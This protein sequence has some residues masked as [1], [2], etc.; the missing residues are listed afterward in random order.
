MYLSHLKIENFR[1]FGQGDSAF[2]MALQ[3]GVT[4]IVGENDAG[5]SAVIDAI[6]L[7]LG[8]NDH[9]WARVEDTDFHRLDLQRE[10]QICCD[11]AGLDE[12]D[13]RT[14]LE[15]LTYPKDAPDAP[16]LQL[17]W[18]CKAVG[19]SAARRASRRCT[20]RCGPD[21]DGPELDMGARDLLRVTYLRPL[22]DAEKALSP[23]RYSRLAQVLHSTTKL[24]D[25]QNEHDSEKP[26][27]EQELSV[28]GIARLINELMR[29]QKGVKSIAEEITGLLQSLSL[30]GDQLQGRIGVGETP[31]EEIQVQRLLE[32]LELRLDGDG[33]A[34]LGSSNV[35]FMACELLLLASESEGHKLLLIEE[36]EAHLHA[37]RQLRAMQFLLDQA[38]TK[39][40]QVLVTT[41]SSHLASSIPVENLQIMNGGRSFSLAPGQTRLDP[42]DYAFLDRFIDATKANLF[43]AKA[44]I[45]VEGH[46]EQLILPVIARMLGRDLT[47]HGVSIVN[48]GGVG[49]RRY[50]RVFMRAEGCGDLKI[51]VACVADR[52]ILPN[53]APKLLGRLDEDGNPKPKRQ[54]KWESDFQTDEA[55]GAYVETL[56]ARSSGQYVST[57]VSDRWTLEYDLALGPMKSDGHYSA[58]AAED[59]YV[60]AMW[61]KELE[62]I[63][64]GK[65]TCQDVIE[66]ARSNFAALRKSVVVQEGCTEEEVLAANVYAEIVAGNISK[67]TVAQCLGR[68]WED[69][70]RKEQW[71]PEDVRSMLPTYLVKAIEHVTPEYDGGGDEKTVDE[72]MGI[73]SSP[74]SVA[75]T[76]S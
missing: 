41:H 43:F 29:S 10:M 21:G 51:P 2:E 16:V 75:D 65:M 58:A 33:I 46:A 55:L 60:A 56:K 67:P 44:V 54:W 36:P 27:G 30:R 74:G 15:Y 76:G 49:L 38:E 71:S 12:D 53:C 59:L 69:K 14:F 4:A 63:L 45:I 6:R 47:E 18:I 20:L 35:L 73:A 11:F 32:K 25:G 34:G 1:M 24:S 7:V 26:L 70:C 72:L 8:T 48:V 42:T 52:D 40:V 37:Q 57:F 17:V 13:Q 28:L 68:I 22:R 31:A 19:G 5:K 64:E 62:A 3:P 61:A 39:G 9:E 66:A 23:G 50:A